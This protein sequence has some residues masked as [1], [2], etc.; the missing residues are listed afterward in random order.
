MTTR[1]V[2]VIAW[3]GGSPGYYLEAEVTKYFGLVVGK[4][5]DAT[6]VVGSDSGGEAQIRLLCKTAGKK[7]AVPPVH[8]ELPGAKLLQVCNVISTA[9]AVVL[10]GTPGGQ[11]VK[12][13]REILK[14]VDT[15]RESWNKRHVFA[16]ADPTP[17]KETAPKKKAKTKKQREARET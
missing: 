16:I 17:P 9:D 4:Y 11:R 14:R 1:P 6:H 3:V 12:L 13:A 5:P 15:C 2:H 7:L 10:M 8:D